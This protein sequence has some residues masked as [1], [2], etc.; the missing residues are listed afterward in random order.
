MLFFLLSLGAQNMAAYDLYVDL[1]CIVCTMKQ[2][3][4]GSFCPI[5]LEPFGRIE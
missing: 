5:H 3:L 1:N 2:M 4:Q